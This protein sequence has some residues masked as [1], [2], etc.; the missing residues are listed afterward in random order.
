ME[1]KI[2]E[3]V[4]LPEVINGLHIKTDGKYIDGTLGAGGHTIEIINK[5]GKVLGIDADESMIEIAVNNIHTACPDLKDNFQVANGNFRDIK[6]IASEL[7]FY[8]VDGVLLDL[9]ISSKHL[10][11][12]N[13]GFSFKDS[14]APLDMRLDTKAQS[15]TAAQL[16]N[17]LR[18]DQLNEMFQL[19]MTPPE[20][21]KWSNRVTRRRVEK[22]FE[23]VGD[24]LEIA[25]E[26]TTTIHPATK[27]FMALR[28]AVNTEYDNLIQGLRDAFELLNP[29]GRIVVI[30][31]HSGEDRIV[32]KYF[33][34]KVESKEAETL[35]EQP[36]KPSVEEVENNPRSRSA[37]VRILTKSNE[38]HKLSQEGP[39]ESS[40]SGSNNSYFS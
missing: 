38:I 40:S 12:D 20:A 23:Q 26:K 36:L 31:F 18:H 11:D 39:D 3:P 35:G 25:P 24:L 37:K 32:K 14:N 29:G 17:A 16:L 28:I 4:M 27:A 34:E 22:P 33:K 10:A 6:K 15:V 1:K 9:G 5:G 21:R 2:H 8:P 19:G 30:S 7:H 13:R